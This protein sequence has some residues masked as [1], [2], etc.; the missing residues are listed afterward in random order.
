MF[1]DVFTTTKLVLSYNL[2][3]VYK[4]ITLLVLIICFF[5]LSVSR[6]QRKHKDSNFE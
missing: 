4:P 1:T 6:K 3:L 5:L 2:I